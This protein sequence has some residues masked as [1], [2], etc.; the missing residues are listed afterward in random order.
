MKTV[1]TNALARTIGARLRAARLAARMTALSVADQLGYK[2]QTQV[3]LAENGERV[4]PLPV[5]MR[6]A[7][8]YAVPLDYLC[9]LINDPIADATETNQGV[10]ANAVAEAMREQFTRLV[11]SVSEQASVTI[12]GYSQD[13]RD[14]QVACTTVSQAYAALKRVRELNLEFDEDWRGT[15]KLVCLL[16]RLAATAAGVSERLERERRIRESLD[17]E[18]LLSDMDGKVRKHLIGLAVRA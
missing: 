1:H 2:G 13:R 4:P 8:L 16:E 14:L 15:A 7:T 3:S 17:I 10:I 6:Y 18:C 12:A 9:G 11:T 5:L